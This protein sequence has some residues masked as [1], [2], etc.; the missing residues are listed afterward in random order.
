LF[1]VEVSP[2]FAD[3]HADLI[4]EYLAGSQKAGYELM[5]LAE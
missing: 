1:G 2:A 4:D 3:A 5:W